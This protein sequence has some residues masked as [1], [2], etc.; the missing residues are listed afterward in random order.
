MSHNAS[1]AREL[2]VGFKLAS[3]N[4]RGLG[5]VVKRAKVFT[6]KKSLAVDIMFLQETHIVHKAKDRLKVGWVDQIYQSSFSSKARGVA[7]LFRKNVSFIHTSTISDP[8]GRF[9]I[10][11]GVLNSTPITFVNIYAPNFDDPLFFKKVFNV[12]PNISDTNILIGGD[13]NLTLDPLLDKQ[14]SKSPHLSNASACLNTLMINSNLVDIWRLTHPTTR[15]YSFF[16]PVHKSHS[17]I[18]YFLLD[19]K[20]LSTVVSVSYHPIVIS[21]HSILSMNLKVG[22]QSTGGCHWRLDPT[23]LADEHF[24]NYIQDQITHFINENDTGEVNDSTLW[25]SLKAVTR[26]HIMSFVSSKRKS[27]STSLRK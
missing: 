6:P 4:V 1:A 17:R 27:E 2:G 22:V 16:S 25:E 8:I 24:T 5:N 20:L 14:S 3:W 12:I 15:D 13:L 21:D 9:F 18:D 11:V 19:A 26:G 10:V 7:I 23:L